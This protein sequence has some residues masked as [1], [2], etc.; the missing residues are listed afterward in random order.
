[1]FPCLNRRSGALFAARMAD[2][3]A[4]LAKVLFTNSF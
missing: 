4:I 1:M 2:Q 3:A